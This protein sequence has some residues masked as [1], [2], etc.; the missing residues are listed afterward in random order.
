MIRVT[1]FI[2]YLVLIAMHE[3]ILREATAISTARIDLPG[4]LVL[5]VAMYK[6]E[7]VSTW[8]GFAAGLVMAAGNPDLFGWH[9]LTM[10]ALG[11]A[12]FHVRERLN[13]E[14][15]YAKL[16]LIA[17]GILVHNTLSLLI[18]GGAG[19]LYLFR[20]SALTGAVYTTVVAWVFFLFKEK[21]ITYQK[22]RAIF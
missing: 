20:A 5:V 14:S 16:V 12:A 13:L 2:L 21:K 15:L 22:V 19:F 17:G 9:A 8:F 18:I 6:P 7:L 10:A 11:L 1:P 4:L 3:V